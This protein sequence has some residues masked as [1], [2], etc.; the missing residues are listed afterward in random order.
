[1]DVCTNYKVLHNYWMKKNQSN[2]VQNVH[3]AITSMSVFKKLNNKIELSAL[4]KAQNPINKQ[5][6]LILAPFCT[7][8]NA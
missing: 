3:L 8:S 2:L 1:M 5:N 6:S 7:Q 4:K